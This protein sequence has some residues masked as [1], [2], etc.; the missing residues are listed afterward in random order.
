[1]NRLK[2]V[3]AERAANNGVTVAPGVVLKE[4]EYENKTWN[5]NLMYMPYP[6]SDASKNPNLKR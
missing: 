1:M 2:D 6:D 3:F 5:E 4:M